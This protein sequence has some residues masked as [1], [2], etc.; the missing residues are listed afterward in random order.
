MIFCFS[1][2]VGVGGTT[3]SPFF[4]HH[5]LLLLCGRS[6]LSAV[7]SEGLTICTQYFVS[8]WEVIQS[9]QKEASASKNTVDNLI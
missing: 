7:L 9:F 1:F 3:G 2:G 6:C 8:S 4:Q 5:S